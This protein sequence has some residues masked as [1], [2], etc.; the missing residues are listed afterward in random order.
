MSIQGRS[1]KKGK[2]NLS[3]MAIDKLHHGLACTPNA[4]AVNRNDSQKKA[5]TS[6]SETACI[7]ATD[8]SIAPTDARNILSNWSKFQITYCY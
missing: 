2:M 7:P 1:M 6:Q 8:G 3:T 5:H 4:I